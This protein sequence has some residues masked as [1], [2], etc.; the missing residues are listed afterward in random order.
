MLSFSER[1][2]KDKV[3]ALFFQKFIA[4]LLLGTADLKFHFQVCKKT[5][6]G[7][8]PVFNGRF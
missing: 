5:S 2:I 4:K 7:K 6:K 3:L 1:T 8:G